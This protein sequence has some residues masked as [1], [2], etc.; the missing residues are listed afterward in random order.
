MKNYIF[1]ISFLVCIA[2]L[3][4]VQCSELSREQ[5][6]V[7][8]SSLYP[9]SPLKK[10]KVL[11]TQ[12]W[13]EVNAGLE[14]VAV[15][16]QL[17]DAMVGFAHAV[18]DL[19]TESDLLLKDVQAQLSGETT[20]YQHKNMQKTLE[21]VAYVKNLIGSLEDV[22]DRVMDGHVSDQAACVKVV[23]DC[24]KKKMERTLLLAP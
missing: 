3:V 19:N 14:D 7:S 11:A 17:E 4:Q 13:T 16:D 5:I 22:F 23:L 15:R 9:V 24:I 1:K 12:L 10:V 6:A 2:T 8:F 18:L 21:D 20:R